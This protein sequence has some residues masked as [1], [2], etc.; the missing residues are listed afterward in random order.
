MLFS[1]F[2]FEE[3]S[4]LLTGDFEEATDWIEHEFARDLLHRFFNAL[5]MKSIYIHGYIDLL[6][7]PREV[8]GE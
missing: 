3:S 5:G 8:Q 6:L 1:N 7:S 2:A 4:Y